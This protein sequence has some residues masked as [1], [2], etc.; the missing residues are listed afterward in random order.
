MNLSFSVL[1]LIQQSWWSK[2]KAEAQ[3]HIN[4]LGMQ[5]RKDC[6]MLPRW[7]LLL[8]VTFTITISTKHIF[9]KYLKSQAL[10]G[11]AELDFFYELIWIKHNKEKTWYPQPSVIPAV[12]FPVVFSILS[13]TPSCQEL[14]LASLPWLVLSALPAVCSPSHFSCQPS[15]CSFGF[16]P[17]VTSSRSFSAPCKLSRVPHFS[18]P[19]D[20]MDILCI[21]LH[22]YDLHQKWIHLKDQVLRGEIGSFNF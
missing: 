18:Y 3:V 8:V 21:L 9:F 22:H 16:S 7:F 14:L 12:T 19:S 5:C 10:C 6:L 15:I 2:H 17:A 11:T 1:S 20:A 4:C 13:E